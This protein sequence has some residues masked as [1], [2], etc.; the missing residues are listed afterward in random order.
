[1]YAYTLNVKKKFS[2]TWLNLPL[3]YLNTCGH[4]TMTE[5]KSC[6]IYVCVSKKFIT[7]FYVQISLALKGYY[8]YFNVNKLRTF[9]G[10]PVYLTVISIITA[11]SGHQIIREATLAI[12]SQKFVYVCV[13]LSNKKYNPRISISCMYVIDFHA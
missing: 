3:F 7:T 10:K 4:C 6:D 13:D 5:R 1:M 12:L 11:F 8:I 2:R 9:N